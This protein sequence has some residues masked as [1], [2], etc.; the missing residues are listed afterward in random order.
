[1]LSCTPP[2]SYFDHAPDA[3]RGPFPRPLCKDHWPVYAVEKATTW[4][5]ERDR[6]AVTS[7]I[8]THE[9]H[10]PPQVT[11]LTGAIYYRPT[12]MRQ[13]SGILGQIPGVTFVFKSWKEIHHVKQLSK[14]K[15]ELKG[16]LPTHAIQLYLPWKFLIAHTFYSTFTTL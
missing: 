16:K 3:L 5:T 7:R 4:G 6:R 8:M 1:M 10:P 14:R 2:L 11:S 12:L 13:I 9:G 15:P